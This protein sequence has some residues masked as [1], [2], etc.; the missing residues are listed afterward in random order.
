VELV[1]DMVDCSGRAGDVV[2]WRPDPAGLLKGEFSDGVDSS[3][4]SVPDCG[5][6][7]SSRTDRAPELALI[8]LS[9]STAA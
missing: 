4:F 5:D 3:A 6:G 9:Q 7:G 2:V 8:D 1:L